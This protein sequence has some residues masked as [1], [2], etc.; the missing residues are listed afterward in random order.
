MRHLP[1]HTRGSLIIPL[2][3][4]CHLEVLNTSPKVIQ[5]ANGLCKKR[6]KKYLSK[7]KRERGKKLNV[8]IVTVF[9]SDCLNGGI[10]WR[11]SQP[12][13]SSVISNIY[14]HVVSARREHYGI[15]ISAPLPVVWGVMSSIFLVNLVDNGL[16]SFFAFHL[17]LVKGR[18]LVLPGHWYPRERRRE[19]LKATSVGWAPSRLFSDTS[20]LR[21][22]QPRQAHKGRKRAYC[23]LFRKLKEKRQNEKS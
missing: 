16:W 6:E 15:S 21:V 18:S 19:H 23:A 14:I 4:G 11:N 17:K 10:R 8:I 12:V 3:D 20:I 1:H 7:I 9:T 22:Q 5:R 2:F 13:H